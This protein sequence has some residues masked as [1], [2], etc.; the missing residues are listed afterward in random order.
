MEKLILT[1]AI[2]GMGGTKEENP[3]IPYTVSEIAREAAAAYNA[4][5]SLIHFHAREDDGSV[6]ER[7]ERFLECAE[8]IRE[9]C[10][11]VILVEP[12]DFATYSMEELAALPNRESAPKEKPLP[13]VMTLPSGTCNWDGY[14]YINTDETIFSSADTMKRLG[15]KPDL[16]LF[17]KGM[18]DTIKRGQAAGHFGQNLQFDFIMGVQI[19]ANVRDLAF[20]ASSLPAG[21]TFTATGLGPNAWHIAAAATL[22]GGH[23]RVG[24]EDSMYLS[25]GVLARSNGELIEKAAA[26]ARLLG[27]E[28]ASPKE[29]REILGL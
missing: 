3:A 1:A 20:M 19:A 24:F 26:I 6:S 22:L 13:E 8:A 14:P 18:I 5:A 29:A 16:E 27:R 4:G 21:S 7:S 15:I 2:C 12:A 17:D 10:P 9:A 11:G 23:V 25:D 28:I